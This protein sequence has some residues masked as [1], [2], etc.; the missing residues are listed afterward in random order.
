MNKEISDF[1]GGDGYLEAEGEPYSRRVTVWTD[2]QWTEAKV[3]VPLGTIVM[4]MHVE[5]PYEKDAYIRTASLEENPAKAALVLSA[6]A[7]ALAEIARMGDVLANASGID[8]GF[9]SILKTAET[10]IKKL[11]RM[12]HSK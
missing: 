9:D 6:Y 4:P 5:S 2:A 1:F 7:K 12:A 11:Q 10:K 3:D 8:I